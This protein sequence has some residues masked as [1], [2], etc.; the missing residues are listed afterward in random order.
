MYG[1]EVY[2]SFPIVLWFFR[3]VLG[4]DSAGSQSQWCG[5][6]YIESYAV[7]TM[8]TQIGFVR[9]APISNILFLYVYLVISYLSDHMSPRFFIPKIK[10]YWSLVYYETST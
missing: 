5:M 9:V 7:V 10:L 3:L 8:T 6:C 4:Q 1:F 2:V